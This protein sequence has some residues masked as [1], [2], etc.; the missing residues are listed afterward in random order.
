MNWPWTKPEVRESSFTD[1]LVRQ[2]LAQNS[3]ASLAA[4]AAT[5]AL[6][7]CA[8]LIGRSFASATVNGPEEI[9]QALPP[10]L[11]NLIGREIVRHGELVLVIDMM[12]GGDLHLDISSDWD[13]RGEH[14]PT[15]WWYR[16]N[17]AGPSRERTVNFVPAEGVL[18]F[19]YSY[20]PSRPW[21]GRGPLDHATLAG[22]LSAQLVGAL[23]DEVGGPR[24]ALLPIPQDG[25]DESVGLLKG[26]IGKLNGGLALV[27]AGDWT[28]SGQKS[29]MSDWSTRRIGADPP[30]ALVELQ[31][32]ASAEI[33]S[34]V[35]INPAVFTSAQGTASRESWRQCLFGVIAPLGEL[36][37]EELSPEIQH[38]D[39]LQLERTAGV[40]YLRPR[41]GI[42]VDG[43]RRHGNRAGGGAVRFDGGG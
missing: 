30:A 6:E 27:E 39:L 7:A 20:D 23:A 16:I 10:S 12:M 36:V 15:S 42:S 32:I 2:I 14:D 35:G 13:V 19:R 38:G 4:P 29:G 21:R 1:E 33:W 5:A 18:H 17:L 24:G 3:G 41:Q 22:K 43:R 26:D 31:Q 40:G 28:S 37:G 11:R 9:T 34:A 8:G 25:G